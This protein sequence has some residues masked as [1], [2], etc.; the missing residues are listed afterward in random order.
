MVDRPLKDK[1]P[2]GP[3]ISTKWDDVSGSGKQVIGV[4]GTPF[5]HRD[6]NNLVVTYVL[7][8]NKVVFTDKLANEVQRKVDGRF[9]DIRIQVLKRGTTSSKPFQNQAIV[10]RIPGDRLPLEDEVIHTIEGVIERAKGPDGGL[11]VDHIIIDQE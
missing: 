8:E 10:A 6:K 9:E 1:R 3:F 11:K 4:T 7:R 5:P 2:L